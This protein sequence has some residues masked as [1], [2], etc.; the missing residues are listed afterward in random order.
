MSDG[1]EDEG[2]LDLA[3]VLRRLG[4]EFRRAAE[5]E[6]PTI[7]WSYATVELETVITRGG[8]GGIRFG[9]VSAGAKLNHEKAMKISVQLSPYGQQMLQAGA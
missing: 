5:V 4:A 7:Q 2:L 8:D 6:E 3:D 9:V 1:D